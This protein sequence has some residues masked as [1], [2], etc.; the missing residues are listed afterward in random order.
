MVQ[1]VPPQFENNIQGVGHN[2]TAYNK[3]NTIT[4]IITITQ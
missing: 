3:N 4:W 2:K 1:K